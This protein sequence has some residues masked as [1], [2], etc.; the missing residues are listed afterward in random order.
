MIKF[1]GLGKKKPEEV[2][3][4]GKGHIPTERVGS[5]SD[6]GFSE[7]EIID[8]LRKEGYSAEEI[9]RSLTQALRIGVTGESEEPTERLPTLREL[10]TQEAPLESS[11]V[12]PEFRE[13]KPIKPEMP[14]PSMQYYPTA[15]Y[16]TEELIESI[17]QE[18]MGELDE[19]LV[20]FKTKYSDLERKIL[21][22][23]HRLTV[24]SKGRTETEQ[25][26]ISKID[27]FKDTID[28]TNGRLSSLE[29]AFKEALPALIESVR[30][31]IELV[32]RF[33]KQA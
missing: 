31:L 32:Q 23:H 11:P 33:K 12:F 16:D 6:K 3:R 27:S 30:S 10:R 1:L 21:D 15:E 26:I 22:I 4:S 17:V 9:D 7:P 8:V 19:K 29:K 28:D 5:L 24:V 25:T 14:E 18:R 13:T 20:E 2:M